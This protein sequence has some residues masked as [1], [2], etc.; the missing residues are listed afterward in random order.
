MGAVFKVWDSSSG[1]VALEPLF[2][3]KE[4]IA[5]EQNINRTP[6]GNATVYTYSTWR[7]WNLSFR[8]VPA[9]DAAFVN[10]IFSG[11]RL[12][13]LEVIEDGVSQ[14]YSGMIV[15]DKSPFHELDKPHTDRWSGDLSLSAY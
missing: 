7:T 4:D 12:C 5:K 15:N 1:S 11:S 9:A 3:I 13:Q 8:L 2:S 6:S 10:S 14:V